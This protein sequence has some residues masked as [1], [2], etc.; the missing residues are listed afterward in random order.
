MAEIIA[1]ER[2]CRGMHPMIATLNNRCNLLSCLT[3]IA[4]YQLIDHGPLHEILLMLTWLVM[5]HGEADTNLSHL[6]CDN[7][8]PLLVAK[9]V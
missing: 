4:R 5:V 6:S 3:S 9:R 8:L 7:V 2:P 1:Q